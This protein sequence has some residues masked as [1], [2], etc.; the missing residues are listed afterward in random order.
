MKPNQG[1][2]LV[3]EGIDGS[4]KSTQAKILLRRLRKEG[5]QAVGLREPTRGKWGKVVKKFSARAGSLSPA[6]Q[7]ALFV[8]DRMEN[9]EDN[10]KP[11]LR[12]G[13]TVILDRYYFSTIAYQGAMGLDT[14]RI[15]RQNEKFAPRPDLVFIFDIPAGKALRRIAGRL[16]RDKLFERR[17]YLEKVADIFR[18]LKGRRFVHIDGTADKNAISREIRRRVR[19]LMAG[20]GARR[21][22]QDC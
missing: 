2:L 6:E 12:A 9:V 20:R 14:R 15:K 8:S 5:V 7:L 10:V 16:S 4:G 3:F 21:G 17:D 18:S 11:A 19:E 13:K 1:F 22:S